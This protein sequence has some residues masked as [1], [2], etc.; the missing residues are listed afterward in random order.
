MITIKQK[1][2]A[3]LLDI[4]ISSILSPV[5]VSMVILLSCFSVIQAF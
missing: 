1:I 4:K 3:T 2:Q 5:N